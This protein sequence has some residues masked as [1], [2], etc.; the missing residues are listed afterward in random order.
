M[1]ILL[2]IFTLSI[3]LYASE[4]DFGHYD[5]TAVIIDLNTSAKTVY[6]THADER[7]NPCSTFKILNSMIAL[8]SDAVHDENETIAWDG[9]V[10]E[11]PA[12]NRDHTMRSAIGVSA[13][14][15][16]QELARRI[17]EKRMAGMVA[18]TQYGNMDTSKTLTN[19]WLGGGSLTISPDEEAAFLKALVEERLPFSTRSMRTV[20]KIITL[21]QNDGYVFG[22]KTGSCGGIGWFVGFREKGESSE[23]FAFQI[24]GTGA[25]GGEAKRIANAFFGEGK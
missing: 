13:V 25:N 18:K 16:Y 15:F 12:W 2:A 9:V 23:V 17:G 5:G 14:W 24:R 21:E 10:R 1:K 7:V 6:G 8:D 4:P 19:F 3:G 20:K 22:G 11:Y